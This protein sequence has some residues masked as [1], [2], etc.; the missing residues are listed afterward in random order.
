[1]IYSVVIAVKRLIILL[2]LIHHLQV[3]Q[4]LNG[5]VQ[6]VNKIKYMVYQIVFLHEK[7]D[8][9][10]YV[11]DVLV[12]I[13]NNEDIG[14]FVVVY[15]CKLLKIFFLYIKI[16]IFQERMKPV[17]TYDIILHLINLMLYYHVLMKEDQ[18]NY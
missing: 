18:K 11:I 5:F 8:H 10:I 14:L 15:L 17:M 13:V 3:Y 7:I 12:M 16:N 4:L 6:F 2:V 9:F 1:V